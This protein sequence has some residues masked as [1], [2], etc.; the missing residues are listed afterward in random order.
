MPEAEKL[1]ISD[2][3]LSPEQPQVVDA[4]I[5]FTRQCAPRAEALYIL[6]DL[7]DAWIGD[8]NDQSP[9]PAIRDA[10]SALSR[11]GTT[12]YLQHGNRDFLLGETFCNQCSAEL[13]GEE[14]VIDLYGQRT[15]LMHGDTLCTDDIAYQQARQQLRNQAFIAAFLAKSLDERRVI[16]AEYRKMSGEATSLLADDIMDVNQQAVIDVMQKH[17]VNRLIHGHTHRQARHQFEMN[18]NSAERIVLGEWHADRGMLLSATHDGLREEQ[19][20]HE[21]HSG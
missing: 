3:H 21:Q 10:L 12:I 6:G 11:Q 20:Q 15:L 2:L 7:F 8:D 18:G 4:F 5:D 9:Y 1:F 17:R 14:H 13:I 19:L 16:T